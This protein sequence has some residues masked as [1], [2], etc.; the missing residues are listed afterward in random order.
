M[1]TQAEHAK[2]PAVVR[3]IELVGVS[4]RSWEDAVRQVVERVATTT[5]HVTGIELLKTT[6]VVRDSKISEYHA[7]VNVAFIVEP[8][9]IDVEK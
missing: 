6:A 9:A 8:A 5:R 3:V 2:G 7:N 4:T 1:S